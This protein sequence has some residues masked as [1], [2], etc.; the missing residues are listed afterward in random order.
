MYHMWYVIWLLILLSGQ[1]WSSDKK[2]WLW[3]RQVVG[4]FLFLGTQQSSS[5]REPSITLRSHIPSLYSTAGYKKYNLYNS[6]KLL[7]T[8]S[9]DEQKLKIKIEVISISLEILQRS[10]PKQLHYSR[11]HPLWVLSSIIW[12]RNAESYS[13]LEY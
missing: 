9:L 10:W 8:M 2:E 1:S 5:S 12:I 4:S 7:P 11:C 13:A 3:T 6:V